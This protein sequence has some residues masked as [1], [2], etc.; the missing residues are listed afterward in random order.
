MDSYIKWMDG[1]SKLVKVLFCLPFVDILWALYRVLGAIKNK[2]WLHLV[3][4]IIWVVF[5]TFIGWVLDL[6]CI[7]IY[8]HI[9]WFKE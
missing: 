7:L 3:L 2:N 5:G 6:L 9:F 4:A 1:R 8:D